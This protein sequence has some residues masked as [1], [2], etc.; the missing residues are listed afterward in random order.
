MANETQSK[1]SCFQFH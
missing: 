1:L